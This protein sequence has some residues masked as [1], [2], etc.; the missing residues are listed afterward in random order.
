MTRAQ[1]GLTEDAFVFCAFNGVWKIA[2]P[3]FHTWLELLREV[4][5]SLLW[6]RQNNDTAARN[7]RQEAV[8][9]GIDPNGWSSPAA[10]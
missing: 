5:G 7:L 10:R 3:V 2:P 6:L 9:G 1:A 8:A 4:P